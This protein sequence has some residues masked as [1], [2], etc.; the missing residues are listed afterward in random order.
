REQRD[1]HHHR[2]IL[3]AD[4]RDELISDPGPLEDLFDD[5]LAADE[6]RQ[7]E[8]YQHD[9]RGQSHTQ[10]VQH[11]YAP[12]HHVLPTG[13]L[14]EITAQRIEHGGARITHDAG[15]QHDGEHEGWHD[16]M[17]HPIPEGQIARHGTS[18]HGQPAEI[19]PENQ[20]GDEAEEEF[21][22]GD[23]QHADDR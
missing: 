10:T 7:A 12:F 5:D 16:Q 1:G 17:R 23:A 18:A 19:E 8:A 13:E 15:G 22:D 14:D 4:G 20:D 6:H 21:G 3:G 2:I 9:H 11:V